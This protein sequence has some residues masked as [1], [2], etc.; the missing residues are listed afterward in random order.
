MKK[1]LL[2][3]GA[4]FIGSHLTHK[5]TELGHEVYVVDPLMVFTDIDDG[6]LRVIQNYRLNHL[7]K[8][9]LLN[10]DIFQAVG[11]DV[12]K[13]FKPDIVV[14]LGAVPLEGGNSQLI[15]SMQIVK[16]TSL[17]YAVAHEA[18]E[19]NVEKIVYLSSLFAYGNFQSNHV[20][21]SHPLIPVTSYGIDKAMGEYI[22]KTIAPRWNII[23]T[24]SIY[25]FGDANVR[26]TS[27]TMDKAISGEEFWIN[28][29]AV[30][31]FIYIKDLIDGVIK[32]I[33][34]DKIN[35]DFHITGGNGLLLAD[36][37]RELKKYFPKLKYTTKSLKDRPNRGTMTNN[38]AKKMLHWQPEIS[39]ADGVED[40]VKLS[41]QYSCG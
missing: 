11:A 4:G 24:T 41:K 1:I 29:L 16:D 21:E 23:R 22:I 7:M 27:V 25:G 33:F 2:V 13:S 34:T 8:D 37:V 15:E 10:R 26:A 9:S 39:L 18:R 38:K 14:H 30:L 3:G 12:M 31:D 20:D 19:H 6:W 32:V 17:T 35:E 40:Y 28:D 36:Y 5:L